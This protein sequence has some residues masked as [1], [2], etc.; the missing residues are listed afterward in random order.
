MPK[1]ALDK[2]F[3]IASLLQQ[4]DKLEFVGYA[5]SVIIL[6]VK[7]FDQKQQTQVKKHRRKYL[8]LK[9]TYTEMVTTDKTKGEALA[10]KINQTNIEELLQIFFQLLKFQRFQDFFQ[11]TTSLIELNLTKRTKMEEVGT[12]T[13]AF[14]Q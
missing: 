3:P 4:A 2:D 1:E 10:E 12:K 8:F 13:T 6:G 14:G 11:L 5:L 7:E 9:E